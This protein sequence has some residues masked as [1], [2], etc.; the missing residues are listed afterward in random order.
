MLRNPARSSAVR[1]RKMSK[2]F[3]D[4]GM[5]LHRE[6]LEEKAL[7]TRQCPEPETMRDWIAREESHPEAA[8][9][10]DHYI[11]CAYCQNQYETLSELQ[12]LADE[13]A[14]SP[15]PLPDSVSARVKKW[16][17]QLEAEGSVFPIQAARAAF[18]LI[19]RSVA[20]PAMARGASTAPALHPS[21]TTLRSLNPVLEWSAAARAQ[22]YI[23]TVIRQKD[24][25]LVWEGSA[26]ASLSFTLPEPLEPGGVYL[27]QVSAR[28]GRQEE[29]S[30]Q[31]GFFVLTEEMQREVAALEAAHE[32][33]A[34]ARLGIYEAYGLYGEALELTE[35]LIRETPDATLPQAL[36][37]HLLRQAF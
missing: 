24:R 19:H 6:L 7:W 5:R 30:A 22:E 14:L 32:N 13:P 21:Y 12:S 36:R 15:I 20:S 11:S 27:W 1:N 35:R 29:A 31:A 10:L 9:L 28:I 23:L 37:H 25:R 4:M 16:M 17:R 33:S 26:G 3:K 18:D 8:S 2:Q 34:M